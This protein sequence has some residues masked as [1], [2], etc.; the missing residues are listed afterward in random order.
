[1]KSKLFSFIAGV[2]TML[3]IGA[4]TVPVLASDGALTLAAYPVRILVNGEVFQPKDA[5]VFIADGVT[6]APVRALAE[7]YGLEVG[8]DGTRNLVTVDSPAAN[9][10]KDFASQWTIREKPVTN[11]GDEKIFTASYNG[12]L[13]MSEFKAWWKSFD[14]AEI[15]AE[16]EVLAADAQSVVNGKV[17][18]YFDYNGY[19]LGTA[20]AFG[21]FEQS[22]FKA[23]GVW[24]K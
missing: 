13:G 2:L 6:Y 7:A 17:T 9:A 16:A 21:A 19:A 12:D 3:L 10:P 18:M 20:Y 4:A 14:L 15:Q 24:I 23:A 11:Y 22:N 8:Y 1:M 5:M